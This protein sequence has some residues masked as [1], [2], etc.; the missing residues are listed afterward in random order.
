M[1]VIKLTNKSSRVSLIQNLHPTTEIKISKKGEIS[2]SHSVFTRRYVSFR[3]ESGTLSIGTSFFNQGCSVT[4]MNCITIGE[5]CLFG[6]NVVI[7]DHDHDYSYLDNRRGNH[8]KYGEVIIGNNVWI[9]ANTVILRNTT[10]GDG[11]VIG[12]GCVIRGNIQSNRII[13]AKQAYTQNEIN[14]IL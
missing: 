1:L 4:A 5:N 12:A 10:I 3:V 11:C 9:G 6:P 14:P 13:K 7:V 8:Y 2:L